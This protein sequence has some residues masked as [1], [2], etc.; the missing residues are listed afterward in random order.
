LEAQKEEGA[1]K[2][3]ARRA[4]CI[5][6]VYSAGLIVEGKKRRGLDRKAAASVLTPMPGTCAN[7]N[8]LSGH[9][10]SYSGSNIP[11]QGQTAK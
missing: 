3:A 8:P 9:L 2:S 6:E 11:S 5:Q 1:V 10:R 4:P 7:A